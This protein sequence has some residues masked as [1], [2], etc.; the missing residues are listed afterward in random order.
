M[1]TTWTAA[2]EMPAPREPHSATSI[3][4]YLWCVVAAV[5]SVSIGAHWDVSWHRSI[6]RDTFW[7]PAHM[8]IYACGVLAAISC[9][10]LVLFTT[11]RKSSAIAA[12][13]VEVFGFRAPLGAFIASWGGIAMLTSAPFDNW[14]HNAY[15]LDVKIVSPPHTLLM[16]GVFAVSVGALI[17]LVGAMNRAIA[18]ENATLA[19]HLQW[20]ILY[21]GGL[22]VVFQMFFRMEYTWDVYLHNTQAYKA[23][24]IGMPTLFA[25]LWQATRNRWA[26][27]WSA[28]IY[29]AFVEGAVLILPLFP[30]EPKLGPVFQQVTHFIPPKFPILLIVPAI[31]LDLL[32]TRTQAWKPWL[33]ALVSGPVFLL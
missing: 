11:F 2:N 10:Y 32:W 7:T 21:V 23:M 28:L 30:A 31:L 18:S 24:A 8:A 15:G 17:M 14:W 26:S 19:R 5:T 3:P 4:W 25:V 27:T 12:S 20:M 6:G 9:G 1:A 13:S 29:M 33:S 22:M 16:L